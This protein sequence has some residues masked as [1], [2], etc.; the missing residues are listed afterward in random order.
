M[1]S[2]IKLA[3]Q[4]ERAVRPHCAKKGRRFGIVRRFLEKG[5]IDLTSRKGLNLGS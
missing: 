5:V 3:T 2:K 4:R 1:P